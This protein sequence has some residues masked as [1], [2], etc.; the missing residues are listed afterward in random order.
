MTGL[1]E[2]RST[3]TAIRAK[4]SVS[5]SLSLLTSVK[6]DAEPGIRIVGD[7]LQAVAEA[8]LELVAGAP[9]IDGV[10]R[11]E[12]VLERVAELLLGLPC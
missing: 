9:G 3:S 5:G 12:A 1:S 8:A 11:V 4:S 7:R 10:D 6:R 2:L